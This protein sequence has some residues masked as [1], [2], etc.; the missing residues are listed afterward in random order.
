MFQTPKLYI[1]ASLLFSDTEML[2]Q[3]VSLLTKY[4]LIDSVR[5]KNIDKKTTTLFFIFRIIPTYLNGSA[6]NV[7]IHLAAFKN[8]LLE[9]FTRMMQ[10][11]KIPVC[12]IAW[13]SIAHFYPL[14]P[15]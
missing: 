2:K 1:V 3:L 5:K 15:A 11:L 4:F 14:I 8:H 9:Q 13:Q 12:S 7:K 10:E 6:C